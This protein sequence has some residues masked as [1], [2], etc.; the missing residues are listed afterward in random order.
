M[1]DNHWRLI[2]YYIVANKT[3]LSTIKYQTCNSL[4]HCRR[5]LQ[6]ICDLCVLIDIGIT[7]TKKIITLTV[8]RVVSKTV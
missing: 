1:D 2:I 3:T 6:F 5:F 7:G 4:T 8:P